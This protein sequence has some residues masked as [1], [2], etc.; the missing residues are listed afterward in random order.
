M[1]SE[2]VERN[3]NYASWDMPFLAD[4]IVNAHHSYIKENIGQIAAYAHKIAAV[5]GDNHPEV[6]KID[7]IFDK[8]ASDMA[9]HLCAEEEVFFPAIKRADATRKAGAAPEAKD[10][11]TIKNLL[12]SAQP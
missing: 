1:K 11:E 9:I 7:T 6:I 12:G 10:I 5:H 3:Q 4:Y 2:P 8:I